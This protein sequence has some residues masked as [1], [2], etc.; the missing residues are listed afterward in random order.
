VLGEAVVPSKL[1]HALAE[2]EGAE[3]DAVDNAAGAGIPVQLAKLPD[4]G[5]P[6]NGVTRV[7]LVAN[8]LAPD[9]VS[10]VRAVA[11][12]AEVNEP[13]EAALPTEVTIP[14]RLAFVTTVAALPTEVTTPVRLALVVTVPAVKLAAVPVQLVST[15]LAGVP[16][17]GATKVLL[18]SV[19]VVA[20]PTKVSVASGKVKVLATV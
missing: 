15:P 7:G 17:A 8:T 16:R 20:F 18:V 5:V 2:Y 19:S 3:P 4:V 12:W 1:T 11:N 9:P 14:V 10:S 6:S 13:K